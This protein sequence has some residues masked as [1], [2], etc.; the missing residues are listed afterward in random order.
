MEPQHAEGSE[1]PETASLSRAEHWAGFYA[2]LVTFE[3]EILD[4]MLQL[5]QRL[6]DAEQKVVDETNLEPMRVLI[7]DFRRRGNNWSKRVADKGGSPG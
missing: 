6:S 7:E 3:E 5:S 1:T 4:Q 2:R